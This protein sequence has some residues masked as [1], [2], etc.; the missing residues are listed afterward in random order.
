MMPGIMQQLGP[1]GAAELMKKAAGGM[2]Q[3]SSAIVTPCVT[4]EAVLCDETGIRMRHLLISA[5][6]SVVCLKS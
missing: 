1:E 3:P 6:E 5:P 4:W 2:V